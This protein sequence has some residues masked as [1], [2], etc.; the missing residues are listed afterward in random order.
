MSAVGVTSWTVFIIVLIFNSFPATA[1]DSALFY[2]CQSCHE[3]DGSGNEAI[4]APSIAG[5]DANYIARQMRNFRDGLRG[6]STRDLAGRQ[7]N[8]IAAIFV[9]DA[10]IAKLSEYVQSMDRQTPL[11]TLAKNQ[12]PVDRMYT[13]CAACHGKAGEG[14]DELR[15]PSLA[16]LDDWYIKSQLLKFRDGTRGAHSDDELGAQMRAA[17][18]S[19]SNEDAEAL[20]A[21]IVSLSAK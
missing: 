17:A 21:Y 8:L 9:D 14:S 20:A 15:A 12:L 16:Y 13:A 4:G 11:T 7:M 19:L 2:S 3:A 10:Q 18:L 1:E 6:A 5:M